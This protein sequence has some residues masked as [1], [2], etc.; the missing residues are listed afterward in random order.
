MALIGL[1]LT[2]GGGYLATQGGSRYFLFMGLMPTVAGGLLI[3]LQP[4]GAWVYA[5]AFLLTLCWAVWEAGLSFWPLFS[6]LY[7]FGVLALLAL[8]LTASLGYTLVPTP[9][10]ST[11]Q[12]VPVYPVPPGAE[13]KNWLH[14]GNTTAGD[15]FAALD[16]NYQSQCKTPASGVGS[17]YRRHPPQQ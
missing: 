14:W 2:A 17:A 11:R 1:A 10:V 13:Q 15:R 4:A 7:M 5:L 8:C 3:G 12:A 9:I 16:Q 6:R